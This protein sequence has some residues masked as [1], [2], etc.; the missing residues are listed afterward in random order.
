MTR[1]P[2]TSG[3]LRILLVSDWRWLQSCT[4]LTNPTI[5]SGKAPGPLHE[6]SA[7]LL[8][9][10]DADSFYNGIPRYFQHV[11]ALFESA[12][13]FAHA[14]DF[15]HLALQALRPGQKEPTFSF[16]SEI[17]SRLFTAEL[18][19]SRFPAAFTALAQFID[20]ALQKSAVIALVDA[21]LSSTFSITGLV[22]GLRLIETLP[23][24]LHPQLSRHIDQHLAALA[25]KQKSIPSL[26]NQL[27]TSDGEIDHL[28]ILHAYRIAQKDYRGAVAVLLDRLRLI[29]KSS[30]ARNDPEAIQIRHALL[31]LINALGCVAPEEA[32]LL[33][34]VEQPRQNNSLPVKS[35]DNAESRKRGPTE[36]KRII[37]TLDDLRREYQQLLDK[38]SRIE[39]GDF[40]F[41]MDEHGSEDDEQDDHG[42][43]GIRNGDAM[44]L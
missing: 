18:K 41:E 30:Q 7:G 19:C 42:A 32:Y 28:M 29:K 15:A 22:G 40:D 3:R 38:C 10:M 25:K 35:G 24:G 16:K 4:V 31:A 17:L 36:R 11:L 6:M 23:I 44:E 27:W 14:A 20:Y 21:I 34:D 43:K 1:H 39:R 33:T 2:S 9:R 13:A 5:A 8:S 26:R 12:R 37:I